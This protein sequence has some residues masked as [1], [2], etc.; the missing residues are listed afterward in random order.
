MR[1][2]KAYKDNKVYDW[3][4]NNRQGTNTRYTCRQTGGNLF[5]TD[6]Q[7]STPSDTDNETMHPLLR[8]TELS[9]QPDTNHQE[10]EDQEGQMGHGVH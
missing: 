9:T 2:L 3:N 10:E 7:M 8:K 5:S 4:N 1:D 6:H